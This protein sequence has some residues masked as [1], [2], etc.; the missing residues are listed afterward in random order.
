MGF[1]ASLDHSG[2]AIFHYFLPSDLTATQFS[3]WNS[4]AASIKD[5]IFSMHSIL[6]DRNTINGNYWQ[7]RTLCTFM[8]K[9]YL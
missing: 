8:R 3:F 5:T 4:T 9:S 7:Q 6:F 1:D 2:V